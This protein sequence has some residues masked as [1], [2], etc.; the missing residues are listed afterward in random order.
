MRPPVRAYSR[1][2]KTAGSAWRAASREAFHVPGIEGITLKLDYLSAYLLILSS[3]II[4]TPFFIVFGW[5]SDRIGRLKL[6]LLAS[7]SLKIMA[8]VVGLNGIY[9]WMK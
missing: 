8:S 4:G 7:A 9:H 6:I 3:L 5:L 2:G 1:Y